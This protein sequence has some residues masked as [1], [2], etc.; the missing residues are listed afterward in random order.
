[1]TVE[2]T[3]VEVE[4]LLRRLGASPP[5]ETGSPA[6]TPNRAGSSP[7]VP[8]RL[9]AV[10]GYEVLG[11]LGRGG[12]G[13]VYKAR[14][15]RLKRLVALNMIRGGESHDP[16]LRVRFLIEAEAVA[17]LDH[18]HVVGLY[19]FGTHEGLPYFALEY[20]GGGNLAGNLRRDGRFVARPAAELVVKLADGI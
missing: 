11:V 12:M 18:P 13:V 2:A 14:H 6:D 1:D 8:D 19:E 9:P 3:R 5:G 7:P 4:D 16:A 20:L 15:L 10:A 17:Q